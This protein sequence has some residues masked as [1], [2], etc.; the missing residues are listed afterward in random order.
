M[1]ILFR[2]D[3][4]PEIGHYSNSVLDSSL[5]SICSEILYEYLHMNCGSTGSSLQHI[6]RAGNAL[7]LLPEV[8]T[9]L[10]HCK[11]DLIILFLKYFLRK[12]VDVFEISSWQLPNFVTFSWYYQ[13]IAL[14]IRVAK[15]CHPAF[16]ASLRIRCR[17]DQFDQSVWLIL[18][19]I[20]SNDQLQSVNLNVRVSNTRRVAIKCGWSAFDA[21]SPPLLNYE[22]R[23]SLWTVGV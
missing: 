6:F 9:F 21:H 1:S 12:I 13:I 3:G 17:H 23:V 7:E 20:V 22:V 5:F 11:V 19:H 2:Y 16:E 15:S 8:M 14:P 4:N 10:I 18:Y